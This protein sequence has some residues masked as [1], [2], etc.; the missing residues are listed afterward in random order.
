[1]A[2]GQLSGLRRNGTMAGETELAGA[3][4][5]ANSEHHFSKEN[6]QGNEKLTATSL[7]TFARTEEQRVRLAACGDLV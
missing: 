3:R 1:V 2:T 6:R 5:P 7:E 4:G